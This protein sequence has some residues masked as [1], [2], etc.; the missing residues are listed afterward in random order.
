[1]DTGCRLVSSGCVFCLCEFLVRDATKPLLHSDPVGL[2]YYNGLGVC[3]PPGTSLIIRVS[4]GSVFL[5][6][7]S[8]FAIVAACA[9][10]AAA[11]LSATSY[12]MA[13]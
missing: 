2:F 5:L 1:M 4:L 13:A 12:W 8:A 11:T 3:I 9:S 10:R 7:L 6:G